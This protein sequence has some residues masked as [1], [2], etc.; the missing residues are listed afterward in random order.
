MRERHP[1]ALTAVLAGVQLLAVLDGLAASLALPQIGHDLDLGPAG[2][3]WVLNATSVAL[4]GGLLVAGRLGDVLGRRPVFLGGTVLLGLGSVVA[5]AAPTAAVLLVGRVVLGLG[6]AVAYPSALALT[7]SLF[8]DE[9]WRTRAFAASAVSGASGALA[10]AVYGGLVTDLLGWR[11]VF[12]L[13]VPIT[14]VL[15]VAAWWVLPRDTARDTPRR[16]LDWPAA[17]LATTAI[18]AAVAGVLGRGTDS[19]SGRA[20]AALLGVALVAVG[21]TVAWERRA[22]DPLLPRAVVGS[23]RLLGGSG[24]IAANSA[25]WSVVVFVLS[26]QLQEAGWSPARAGLA[27]LP[28]SAGIVAGGVVVVPWLR[29]RVGSVATTVVGL[30]SGALAAGALALGSGDPVFL[31][32]I[33]PALLLLGFALSAAATGLK[34]HTLKDG[35][36]GA[37]GVSAAVFE[38]STHVGGAVSVALFAGV[39]ATGAFAPAYV[40]AAVLGLLGAA[41]VL[42]L[43]RERAGAPSEQP[44]G[45]PRGSGRR[46]RCRTRR[47]RRRRRPPGHPGRRSSRRGS[48]GRCRC[49][50]PRSRSSRSPARPGTSSSPRPLPSV[51]TPRSIDRERGHL[52]LGRAAPHPPAR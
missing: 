20:S 26:Q 43:Q 12:W 19:T 35:P 48:A 23:R 7:S 27:I 52:G 32:R 2:R 10:G 29:R 24:G 45:T 51:T 41:C 36:P 5:A 16:S 9:P 42:A 1:A 14:L 18:T 4:A 31:T 40:V 28:C 15:L 50:T 46:S 49:R 22:A 21:A 47:R 38:S 13:T 6:A 34:E 33:L 3:A 39:L 17:V 25:L 30:V 44:A 11:F 37:E 8:P